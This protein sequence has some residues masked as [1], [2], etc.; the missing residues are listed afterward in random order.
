MSRANEAR[1]TGFGTLPN[2][3]AVDLATVRMARKPAPEPEIGAIETGIP[4]P[5]KP[6]KQHSTAAAAVQELQPG[7]SR[8]F[9]NVDVKRLYGCAK[10]AK[11]KGFGQEYAVRMMDDGVRVWRLA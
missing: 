6:G 1:A 5:K 9:R 2:K 4:V 11:Q 8:L 10:V 3:P 7:Q